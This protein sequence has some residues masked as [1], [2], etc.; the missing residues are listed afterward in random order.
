MEEVYLVAYNPL[1]PA[2]YAAEIARV[3][4]VLPTGLLMDTAHFN[5]TA[6][7]GMLARP[8]IEMLTMVRSLDEA[9]ARGIAHDP[10]SGRS[11]LVDEDGFA[12]HGCHSDER[13]RFSE[14]V[15][16]MSDSECLG[17]VHRGH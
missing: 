13:R 5:S 6:I 3:C 9:R 1:W 7:P 14:V 4:A 12:P 10:G 15:V 8:V 2:M 16:H 17:R 11:L